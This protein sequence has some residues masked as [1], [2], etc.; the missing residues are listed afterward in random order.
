MSTVL[1]PVSYVLC[2][3][4]EYLVFGLEY[5]FGELLTFCFYL[6]QE[7]DNFLV[8]L[9]VV[10]FT[11]RKSWSSSCSGFGISKKRDFR[12]VIGLP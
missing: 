8:L 11:C 6:V 4:L 5:Q 12:E 10:S 2:P 7:R 1:Y 3:D 9:K